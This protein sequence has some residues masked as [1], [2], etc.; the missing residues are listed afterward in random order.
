LAV[1]IVLAIIV[2]L[3]FDQRTIVDAPE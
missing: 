1:I 2:L 3:A